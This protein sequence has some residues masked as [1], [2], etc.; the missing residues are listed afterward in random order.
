MT[1]LTDASD[2]ALDI[3]S[4]DEYDSFDELTQESRSGFDAGHAARSYW[5]GKKFMSLALAYNMLQAAGPDE[6]A[7]DIDVSYDCHQSTRSS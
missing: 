2:D 4:L 5:L 1:S 6:T 3:S 7:I